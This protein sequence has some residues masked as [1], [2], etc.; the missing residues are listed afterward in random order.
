MSIF[1]ALPSVIS[2]TCRNES[3]TCITWC[4]CISWS[5]SI[6]SIS[7]WIG[8]VLSRCCSFGMGTS[9][10]N[11][12]RIFLR[13]FLLWMS[14]SFSWRE[15]VSSVIGYSCPSLTIC[16][17]STGSFSFLRSLESRIVIISSLKSLS[18]ALI[19][20]S[21]YRS[22]YLIL[23]SES[24]RAS[25]WFSIYSLIFISS[26]SIFSII[27]NSEFTKCRL[28]SFTFPSQ[29]FVVSLSEISSEVIQWIYLGLDLLLKQLRNFPTSRINFSYSLISSISYLD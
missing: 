22:S 26:L 3:R 4:P 25:L 15:D 12:M 16:L 1:L 2:Y 23:F 9:S 19:F 29:I 28:I 11:T 5:P 18:S 10:L 27:F 17:S 21:D 20:I 13:D 6:S 14:L 24:I 7:A 8:S